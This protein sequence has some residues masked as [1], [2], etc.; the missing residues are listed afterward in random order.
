MQLPMIRAG[1]LSDTHL[2][3][4]DSEFVQ[5]THHCFRSCEIVIHAGDLTSSSI[6]QVFAGKTVHAVCGNMCTP[7][8]RKRYQPHLQ[9]N[10]GRFVIGLTHGASLGP[11]R[12]GDLWRLF[13]EADCIISGHT[14]RP[15]CQ[16]Y[17]GILFL[18]PGSFRATG[19]FGAPGTYALL[20]AGE[21]LT[22][23]ILPV[24]QLP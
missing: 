5:L 18:N 13:P 20:E 12:E 3:S 6:L 8:V 11:D 9:F 7:E 15:T 23:R 17:G 19:P 22:A 10:L 1:I 16:R 2:T 14:H 21:E 24:P 4:P